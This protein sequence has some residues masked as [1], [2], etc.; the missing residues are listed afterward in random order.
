[1]TGEFAFYYHGLS[2]VIPE[3]YQIVT[4]AK[5][6]KLLDARIEQIYIRDDIL[7]LGIV[8]KEIDEDIEIIAE[9]I[10]DFFKGLRNWKPSKV[11][12]ES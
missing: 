8:E 1:M 10:V 5:A 3:K 2:D 9:G 12:D 7:H 11:F 6:V 4:K